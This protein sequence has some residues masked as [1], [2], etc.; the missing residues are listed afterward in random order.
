LD[1]GVD[2]GDWLLWLF[3]Q[4]L[5][6]GFVKI[7]LADL[8]ASLQAFDVVIVG[9]ILNPDADEQFENGQ[10]WDVGP[11]DEP[12]PQDGHAVLYLKAATPTGPFVWCSWGQQQPSTLAWKNACLQQAF[13][14]VTDPDAVASFYPQ[15]VA[16]LKALKG[17]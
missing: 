1:V 12:D 17:T 13:A 16:D 9:V 6:K 10:A 4:G 11:G 5:V 2:L 3:N 14:V 7:Q 15:L 8:D